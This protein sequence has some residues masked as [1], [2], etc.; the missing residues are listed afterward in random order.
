MSKDKTKGDK[1]KMTP[2]TTTKKDKS[3]QVPSWYTNSPSVGADVGKK[4][5]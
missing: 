3:P 4:K 1:S 2:K 5:K